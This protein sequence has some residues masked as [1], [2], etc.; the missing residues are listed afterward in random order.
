[1]CGNVAEWCSDFYSGSYFASSPATDP[2]GPAT[3]RNHVNHGGDA[4]DDDDVC[5]ISHR[6]SYYESNFAYPT[7]GFRV[8]CSAK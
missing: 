5:R 4:W 8:A 2:T 6:F 1:M 3:G 7:L